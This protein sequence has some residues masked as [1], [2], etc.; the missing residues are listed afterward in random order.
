MLKLCQRRLFQQGTQDDKNKYILQP[1]EMLK[2]NLKK[3]P[4]VFHP[5]VKKNC[6]MSCEFFLLIHSRV[7][8]KTWDSFSPT[9]LEMT[10]ISLCVEDNVYS[11]GSPRSFFFFF[12][13]IDIRTYMSLVFFSLIDI[14]TNMEGRP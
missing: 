10:W 6:R 11:Q 4:W 8:Q 1:C 14:R 9:K 5:D 13:L 3:R 2:D 12:S 7:G